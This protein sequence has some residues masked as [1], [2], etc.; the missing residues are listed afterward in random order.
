[1]IKGIYCRN[2]KKLSSYYIR[3]KIL[4]D[5]RMYA[6]IAA[7]TIIAVLLAV[8]KLKVLIRQCI[9]NEK[10]KYL[11][12]PYHENNEKLLSVLS[13]VLFI[14]IVIIYMYKGYENIQGDPKFIV[15]DVI[16][17]G[18]LTLHYILSVIL[19]Y[20]SKIAINDT[21]LAVRGKDVTWKMLS[22]MR[23][24]GDKMII[25]YDLGISY[26]PGRYKFIVTNYDEKVYE[27]ISNRIKE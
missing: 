1:M 22:F 26:N 18:F 16:F 20:K 2:Y 15:D 6:I 17:M 27:I 19:N 3:G 4:G 11:L 10:A 8:Y 24:K 9:A 5:E 21:G 23:R 12:T 25:C 7:I 13:F 14:A